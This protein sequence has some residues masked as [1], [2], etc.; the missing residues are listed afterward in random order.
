LLG[1]IVLAVFILLLGCYMIYW[2]GTLITG[3]I[4]GLK[5]ANIY[6]CI[7]LVFLVLCEIILWIIVFFLFI[8]LFI[9]IIEAD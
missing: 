7:G 1:R 4:N 2:L 5:D 9:V 8:V 6:E 3:Q